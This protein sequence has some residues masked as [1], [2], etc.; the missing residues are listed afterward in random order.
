LLKKLATA[1]RG[2]PR[3]PALPNWVCVSA[4]RSSLRIAADN[5]S[6]WWS[7]Y[8]VTAAISLSLN[9]SVIFVFKGMFS[10]SFGLLIYCLTFGCQAAEAR[11]QRPCRRELIR[12]C[13]SLSNQKVQ[14]PDL[15]DGGNRLDFTPAHHVD[16]L[17][18]MIC[19]T[20]LRRRRREVGP[21]CMM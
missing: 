4:I 20:C 18:E 11:R 14:F 13:M 2:C 8:S 9:R 5:D 15:I 17:T 10:F 3:I 6:S 19:K 21:Y 12:S 16:L 1:Y 7:A